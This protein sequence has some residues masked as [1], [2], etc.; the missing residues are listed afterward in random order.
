[1]TPTIAPS[2]ATPAAVMLS[3]EDE[4]LRLAQIAS[5]IITTEVQQQEQQTHARMEQW[6][7]EQHL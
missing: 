5:K 6:F 3:I 2:A 4:E 7:A 1:V